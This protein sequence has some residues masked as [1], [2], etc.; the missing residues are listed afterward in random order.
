[1]GEICAAT[2]RAFAKSGNGFVVIK[3]SGHKQF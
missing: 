1:L 3:P 2:T